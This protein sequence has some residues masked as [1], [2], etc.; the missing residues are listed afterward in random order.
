MNLFYRKLGQ[1]RPIFILHGLFGSSDNWQTL[2]KK[3]AEHFEVYLIDQRNH[4]QSFH[5]EEWNY[6]AMSEDLLNLTK[7]NNLDKIM[8]I[9][10]SMGGKAAMNFTVNHPEK[11]E[12]IIVVDIAPKYY[13]I[14]HRQILDALVSLN[15]SKV[16]SRKEA[17]NILSQKIEDLGELQFLLKNLYWKDIQNKQLSWR[18]NLDVINRKIEIVGEE[19]KAENN[20]VSIP[21]LFLR[22]EKSHYILEEDFSAIKKS[23]SN[24][25]LETI[26][27]ARHW[28]QAE[29]PTLFYEAAISFLNSLE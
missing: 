26:N 19:Q 7:E 3:F 27:G 22:G 13:P 15:L 6:H 8:L 10:H 28:V 2:G 5:S 11:V 9:G 29:Q 14:H 24:V 23:F 17:E 20:P 16:S 1:G 21:T 18:F 4:G 25:R 12:K